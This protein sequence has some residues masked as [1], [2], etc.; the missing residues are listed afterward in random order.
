MNEVTQSPLDRARAEPGPAARPDA[1]Y[2]LRL[3]GLSCTY[4]GDAEP[5]HALRSIDLDIARGTFTAV[6]GPSGS[7]KTTM[8][9]CAAGLQRPTSGSVELGGRDLA[10]LQEPQL[11]ALRRRELG[12]V[13]QS[14]NLLAALTAVENVELPLRLD[15][16]SADRSATMRLL[17]R[18]GLGGRVVGDHHDGLTGIGELTQQGEDLA[19]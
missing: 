14:F 7:G 18:V 16:R 12:F 4:P 10:R 9:H 11:A 6:M 17:T 19:R 3:R 1:S 8:L 13:F 15:G 2:A 5:V